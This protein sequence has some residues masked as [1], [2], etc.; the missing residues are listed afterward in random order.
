MWI[1]PLSV[2]HW[3]QS[4]KCLPMSG[5]VVKVENRLLPIVLCCFGLLLILQPLGFAMEVVLKN[6]I[7]LLPGWDAS[8]GSKSSSAGR[9]WHCVL[10]QT[11]L[12]VCLLPLRPS[13]RLSREVLDALSKASHLRS[14]GSPVCGEVVQGQ[15][16]SSFLHKSLEK[17]KREV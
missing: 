12:H 2:R 16:S 8:W 9:T 14:W 4:S 7:S 5:H 15:E 13:D 1:T 6:K 11:L 10:V 17:L 3:C